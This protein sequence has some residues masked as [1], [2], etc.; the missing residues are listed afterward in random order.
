MLWENSSSL[1]AY[2]SSV[3]ILPCSLIR[4]SLLIR[5]VRGTYLKMYNLNLLFFVE[6]Q[7]WLVMSALKQMLIRGYGLG[8]MMHQQYGRGPMISDI[9]WD[10]FCI[11]M[12]LYQLYKWLQC[13]YTGFV[14]TVSSTDFRLSCTRIVPTISY[15]GIGPTVI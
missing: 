11:N 13:H 10:Q 12:E 2:W 8:P 6:I 5:Q 4:R 3:N 14:P 15:T 7:K 1:H 9:P